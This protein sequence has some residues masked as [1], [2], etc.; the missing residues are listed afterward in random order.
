MDRRHT[1][2]PLTADVGVSTADPNNQSARIRL[3]GRTALGRRARALERSFLAALPS[4]AA[5]WQKLQCKQAALLVIAAERATTQYV[6][7]VA[8]VTPDD[9]SRLTSTAR[10][11]VGD[12]VGIRPSDG[13]PE[14]VNYAAL[15]LARRY[16][17]S[18][19]SK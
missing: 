1:A 14:P 13:E 6:L 2:A 12:V 7:G 16:G 17:G 11:H 8:G 18:A 19:P 15:A 3:D 10:R 5:E 4:D 9:I